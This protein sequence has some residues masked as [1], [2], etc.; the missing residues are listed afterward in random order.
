MG[1]WGYGLFQSDNELDTIEEINKEAGKLANDSTLNL[2]FP[3]NHSEIVAKLNAGLFHQVLDSWKHGI[4]YLGA[5]AM[6]LGVRISD[7]DL[8]VLRDTLPRAKMYDEA[9]AQMRKGLDGHKNDGEPWDF[10]SLGLEDTMR[11]KGENLFPS[12]HGVMGMNVVQDF[13]KVPTSMPKEGQVEADE[14]EKGGE[15]KL[16]GEQGK[17]EGAYGKRRS[18]R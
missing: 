12:S 5:L 15:E 9:K 10:E 7:Q 18:G 2:V 1:A 16:R 13:G 8:Q 14:D 17:R 4:I 11:V 6:Q 3:E